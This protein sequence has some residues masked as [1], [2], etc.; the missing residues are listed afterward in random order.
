MC[1]LNTEKVPLGECCAISETCETLIFLMM[2]MM[3]NE[4]YTK[5][6][7]LTG[8]NGRSSSS[9]QMAIPGFSLKSKERIVL[10]SALPI[11]ELAR[12]LVRFDHLASTIVNANRRLM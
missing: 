1:F 9:L 8:E 12:V 11:F 2:L 5:K 7:R 3:P 6:F 10:A 4:N